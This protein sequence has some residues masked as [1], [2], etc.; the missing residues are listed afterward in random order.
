MD[1]PDISI[2][3]IIRRPNGKH[4][5]VEGPGVQ[6]YG[7]EEFILTVSALQECPGKIV[8]N[9]NGKSRTERSNRSVQEV[10]AE[11][12]RRFCDAHNIKI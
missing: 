2:R 1:N 4:I 7:D 9:E 6:A 3:G 10:T 8:V 5:A 11:V 12:L